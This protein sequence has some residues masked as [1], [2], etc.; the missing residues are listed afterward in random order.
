MSVI[1]SFL[2][3]VSVSMSEAICPSF[4]ELVS[5]RLMLQPS[6][7][8]PHRFHEAKYVCARRGMLLLLLLLALPILFTLGTGL[9]VSS[10]L[11][12]TRSPF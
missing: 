7:P 9:G 3:T 1:S 12:K 5:N 8:L 6:G 4:P 2:R 10:L 11:K